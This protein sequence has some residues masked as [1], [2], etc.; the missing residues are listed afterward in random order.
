MGTVVGFR[1]MEAFP[2][3]LVSATEVAVTVIGDVRP[4]AIVGGVYVAWVASVAVID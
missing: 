2:V 3:L 4:A 1:A